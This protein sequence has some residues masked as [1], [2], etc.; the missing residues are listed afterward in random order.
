MKHQLLTLFATALTFSLR[1]E[2]VSTAEA[3]AVA[4]AEAKSGAVIELAA[5]TFRLTRRWI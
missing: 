3:L 1:A 2:P 5:G 4:V